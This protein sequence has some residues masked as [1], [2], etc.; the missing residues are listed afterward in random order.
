MEE[1]IK[2]VPHRHM[3]FCL[4]KILREGFMRNTVLIRMSNINQAISI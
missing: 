1:M 3:I 2:Q 4:P